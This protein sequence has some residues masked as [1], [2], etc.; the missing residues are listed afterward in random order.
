M[1]AFEPI[2]DDAFAL[3]Q[4]SVDVFDKNPAVLLV[5]NFDHLGWSGRLLGLKLL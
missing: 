2:L 1:H 4:S 3:L 5:A